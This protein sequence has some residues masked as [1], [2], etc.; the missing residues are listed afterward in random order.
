[1]ADAPQVA[2]SDMPQGVYGQPAQPKQETQIHFGDVDG[3]M[4]KPATILGLRRRNFWI[5]AAILLAV[6]GATVGGS[7]GGSLAVRNAG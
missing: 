6:V 5:I 3:Q 7:V 1:M 2:Y 4:R